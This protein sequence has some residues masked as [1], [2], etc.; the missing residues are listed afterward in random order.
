MQRRTNGSVKFSIKPGRRA[1]A[2]Q[3]AGDFTGWKPVT[4]RRCR[5]NRFV[6]EVELV[7]GCYDYGF[8]IDG[9]WEPDPDNV[10]RSISPYRTTNSV[11]QV[12]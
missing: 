3:L 2:V 11:A 7:A 5:D 4:M 6:L 1:E 10:R 12:H 9:Q 8:I